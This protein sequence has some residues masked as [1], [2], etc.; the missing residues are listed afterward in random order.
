MTKLRFKPDHPE[1]IVLPAWIRQDNV[2]FNEL[3]TKSECRYDF[4]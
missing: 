2:R 1:K 3:R 4:I